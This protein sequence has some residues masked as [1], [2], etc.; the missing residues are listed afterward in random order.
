MGQVQSKKRQILEFSKQKELSA[1][2]NIG[3]WDD[4]Y[5]KPKSIEYYNGERCTK[6][7]RSLYRDYSRG[8][9]YGYVLREQ[10][11][12]ELE[13]LEAQEL[14]ERHTRELNRLAKYTQPSTLL[15]QEIHQEEMDRLALNVK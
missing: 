15:E 9:L 14:Q 3:H 1:S 5:D 12:D 8:Y 7:S 4:V 6:I 13:A 11:L 2:L 10:D